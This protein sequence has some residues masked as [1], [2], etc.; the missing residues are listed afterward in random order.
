MSDL[1]QLEKRIAAIEERNRRVEA[2]K[3][4][5]VSAFRKVILLLLTYAVI[6]GLFLASG[7]KQAWL[8]AAEAAIGFYISTFVLGFVKAWWIKRWRRR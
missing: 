1:Q 3:A 5:E 6:V 4:W 2:D 8:N 7:V